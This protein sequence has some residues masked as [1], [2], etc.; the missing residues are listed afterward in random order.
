MKEKTDG[1]RE[2]ERVTKK[3][4]KRIGS[5]KKEEIK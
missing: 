2:N 5:R 1:E 4:K 3:S